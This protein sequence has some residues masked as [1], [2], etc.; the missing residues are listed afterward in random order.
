ML[1]SKFL[2]TLE[3]DV[4]K[5]VSAVVSALEQDFGIIEVSSLQADHV[6]WRT[7][8]LEE[9]TELV[10]ALLH[11]EE[12]NFS[13]LIKSEIG[14]RPIATFQLAKQPIRC[15]STGHEISVLEI[16]S[17]KAKSPYRSGLEHVEF[18]IPTSS[19]GTTE[20]S[21]WNDAT[22]QAA[23]DEFMRRRPKLVDC[24]NQE[25]RHKNINP[26]ISIKLNLQQQD[27]SNNNCSVKFHLMPLADVIAAEKQQ[28][29][30]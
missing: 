14:G 17:P 28:L 2:T 21:P 19:E 30:R 22:H 29:L 26:D 25:A 8:T 12:N 9:Y 11:D 1:A 20:R 5:F 23:F 3:Q 13:L 6:C 10:A 7:E 18:V 4:P 16:P 15:N 27:F 24:W